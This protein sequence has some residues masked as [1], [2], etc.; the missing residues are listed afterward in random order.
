MSDAIQ[1]G[2]RRG[3]VVFYPVAHE[4]LK[5]QF[6]YH[7]PRPDQIPRYQELRDAGRVLAEA[8]AACCPP[9]AD[10]SAAIRKVREA[11]MTA[12]AAIAL[13]AVPSDAP[14]SIR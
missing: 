6:T 13:E 4:V 11:V 1:T 7:A 12:N 10:T 14:V 5:E 9:C 8:I 2:E 3:G